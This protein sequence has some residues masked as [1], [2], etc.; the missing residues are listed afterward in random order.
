MLTLLLLL[1]PPLRC[2]AD[3]GTCVRASF[4][5]LGM[6][7]ITISTFLGGRCV[8]TDDLD[9]AAEAVVVAVVADVAPLLP[10]F[11][12]LRFRDFFA[13][14]AVEAPLLLDDD[15]VNDLFLLLLPPASAINASFFQSSSIAVPPPPASFVPCFFVSCTPSNIS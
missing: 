9:V 12:D 15:L 5:D 6:C 2:A 8:G 13:T 1:L 10:S 11:V 3:G 14:S 4:R 7:G